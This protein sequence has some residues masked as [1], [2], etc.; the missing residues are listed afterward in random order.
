MLKRNQSFTPYDFNQ[1]NYLLRFD[2]ICPTMNW[3]VWDKVEAILISNRILPILAVVPDSQDIN[4]VIDP[5]CA[6]FWERVRRWQNMGF[7]IAI[8]G[9]QHR[10]VNDNAG[11]MRLTYQSEFAGLSREEQEIKLRKGLEIFT[12]NGVS[13]D[14][15]VAPAHSFDSI[16]V[17][18]LADLG[19]SVISDGLWHWPFTDIHGT[20]WIPQQLWS[21]VPKT[22]GIWTVCCHHNK[23]TDQ[24]IID[25][26]NN[27]QVYADKMTDMASVINLF[28][29]RTLTFTDRWVAFYNWTWGHYLMPCRIRIRRAINYFLDIFK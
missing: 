18:V 26:E 25:F 17:A 2:D 23:W 12:A 20:T 22:S 3:T 7:S 16:T 24:N 14:A 29:G 6:D 8:H 28:S 9:Y 13:A 21:F 19:I 11:L 5:A 1:C 10:Y 15:W 4:L 27:L